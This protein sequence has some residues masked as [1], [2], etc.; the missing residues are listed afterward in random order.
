MGRERI[1][2]VTILAAIILAAIA[3]LPNASVYLKRKYIPN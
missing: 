2:V 3:Y 1:A